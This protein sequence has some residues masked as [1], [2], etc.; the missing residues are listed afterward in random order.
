MKS[1]FQ[2]LVKVVRSLSPLPLFVLFVVCVVTAGVSSVVVLGQKRERLIR[3][4]DVQCQESTLSKCAGR[5]SLVV[6]KGILRNWLCACAKA[7]GEVILYLA[8]ED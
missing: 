5:G 6:E 4:A 7:D 2:R 8:P 3:Q 1:L